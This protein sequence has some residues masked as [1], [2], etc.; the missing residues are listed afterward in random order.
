MYIERDTETPWNTVLPCHK[1]EKATGRKRYRDDD[2]TMGHMRF[3]GKKS[4]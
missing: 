3:C 2:P 4:E 1:R